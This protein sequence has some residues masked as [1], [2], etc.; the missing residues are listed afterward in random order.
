MKKTHLFL[1]AALI[2]AGLTAAQP[3]AAYPIDCA[4]LLCLA[5]GFPPSAECAAAKAT[6]IR[7][8]TPWPVTP[9]LQLW[10]CPMGV[11]ADIAAAIGM[12]DSGLGPDGLPSEVRGY[13]DAI[14]IYHVSR[15]QRK[16]TGDNNYVIDSTTR[17]EY[18]ESGEFRWV[19]ASFERGP[20]WLAEVAGGRVIPI[21]KCVSWGKENCRRYEVVGY[22]NRMGS[23]SFSFM[24]LRAVMIRTK[25]HEGNFNDEIVRY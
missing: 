16:D 9:P 1:S 11:P 19:P 23:S 14:E 6:M 21:R 15:Y 2:G 13:R 22:E 5:G 20:A 25:D 3:A 17:G 18:T 7:R 12:V 4:I 10:N 8:I 24:S